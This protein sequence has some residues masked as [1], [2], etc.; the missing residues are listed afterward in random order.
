MYG[1]KLEITDDPRSAVY[2]RE[3]P[4]QSIITEAVVNESIPWATPIGFF[5]RSSNEMAQV[6]YESS[7]D[8]DQAMNNLNESLDI[9]EALLD[10]KSKANIEVAKKLLQQK[11]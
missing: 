6:L 5:T 3:E 1:V 11:Y 8:L 10:N 9:V 7:T 4:L 2:S